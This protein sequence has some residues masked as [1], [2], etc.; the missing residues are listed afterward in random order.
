M[1]GSHV[2]YALAE[3]EPF[4]IKPLRRSDHPLQGSGSAADPSRR[5]AH[6]PARARPTTGQTTPTTPL[7]HRQR[8]PRSIP[9][10]SPA[11]VSVLTGISWIAALVDVPIMIPP[12]LFDGIHATS[13]LRWR[14][15]E[16]P[17]RRERA[18]WRSS[19][20]LGWSA[21]WNAFFVM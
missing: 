5:A 1:T 15:V 7:S 14:V 20:V 10:V 9:P 11:T 8:R 21:P 12:R 19:F 2:T 6:R 18:C 16:W 4:Q 17:T 13:A 3:G